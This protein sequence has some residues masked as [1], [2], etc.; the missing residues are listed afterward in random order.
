MSIGV[1][2]AGM[3]VYHVWVWCPGTPEK[4]IRAL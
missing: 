1:L 3:S 4:D 2:F